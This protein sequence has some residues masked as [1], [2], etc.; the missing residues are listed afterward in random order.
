MF[1]QGQRGLCTFGG[2]GSLR[3]GRN[4]S[5]EWGASWGPVLMNEARGRVGQGR[6]ELL[7]PSECSGYRLSRA[8]K[9]GDT[10][11]MEQAGAQSW[12]IAQAG[13]PFH[14]DFHRG[15]G[16]RA[17]RV[18]MDPSGIASHLQLKLVWDN[19]PDNLEP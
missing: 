5:W 16:L 13:G 2:R 9:E 4:G 3:R 18:V 7:I 15:Q 14:T 11:A 8:G 19:A 6:N 1:F 10:S 17:G 12:C